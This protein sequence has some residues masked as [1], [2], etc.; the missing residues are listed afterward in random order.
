MQGQILNIGNMVFLKD[1]EN[2]VSIYTGGNI[3]ENAQ[4]VNN[5]PFY[6]YEEFLNQKV[7]YP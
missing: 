3:M 6:E 5:D 1:S 7:Y 2:T 4:Y